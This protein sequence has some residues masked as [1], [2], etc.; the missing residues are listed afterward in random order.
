M[1]LWSFGENYS[2]SKKTW[3]L[4]QIFK[5][6]VIILQSIIMQG[7]QDFP[8]RQQNIIFKNLQKL[9]SKKNN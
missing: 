2:G 6:R 1:Y 9:L 4:I 7:N 3:I 8:G 5:I